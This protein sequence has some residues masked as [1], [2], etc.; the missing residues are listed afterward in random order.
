MQHVAGTEN[1]VADC[2]SRPATV[3]AVQHVLAVL[4]S[5][6]IDYAALA[7]AQLDC[8]DMAVLRAKSSLQLVSVPVAGG[9]LMEDMSTGVLQPLVPEQFRRAVFD[10]VHEVAHAGHTCVGEA[11]LGTFR[12]AWY[13]KA[14]G[15]LGTRVR[16]QPTGQ[17]GEARAPGAGKDSHA[18]T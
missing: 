2:L 4:P 18:G 14:G 8:P 6:G 16:G 13:G 17:S 12:V 10:S 1:V 5:S 15:W 9:L 3:E 7:Q 11:S